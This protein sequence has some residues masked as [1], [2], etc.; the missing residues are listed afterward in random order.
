MSTKMMTQALPNGTKVTVY[1]NNPKLKSAYNT[2]DFEQW[3]IE[4]I[5]KCKSNINY[6]SEKYCKIVHIDHGLIDFVPYPFQRVMLKHMQ[7]N[8]FS[9]LKT[10]RQMGKCFFINTSVETRREPGREPFSWIK[11]LLIKLL[12]GRISEN[13]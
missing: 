7:D 4:E 10:G 8:R 12:K 2:I 3:Q 11:K 13:L 5:I 9:I 6:F 1:K